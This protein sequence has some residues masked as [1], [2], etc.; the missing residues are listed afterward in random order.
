MMNYRGMFFLLL[1]L[2]TSPVV[3]QS[4]V[5]GEVTAINQGQRTLTLR[6]DNGQ[7]VTLMV[8]R[9]T[10]MDTRRGEVEGTDVLERLRIGSEVEANGKFTED[11][12]FMADSIKRERRGRGGN[13][14]P[15]LFPKNEEQLTTSRPPIGMKFARPS[16]PGRTRLVV[17][18]RDL[19]QLATITQNEI[20][21]QPT[22][23][24]SPG[25][26]S[27]T[28]TTNDRFGHPDSQEWK[29]MINPSAGQTP[30]SGTVTLIPGLNQTVSLRRPTVKAVFPYDI[31][32]NSAKMSVD[33]VD[34]SSQVRSTNR[35]VSWV[36]PY[37]LDYGAHNVSLTVVDTQGRAQ[38]E[39]W[40][41]N[42]ANS[43]SQP[44]PQPPLQA[45]TLFSPQPGAVV[46][47]QFQLTGKSEPN[48]QVQVNVRYNRELIKGVIGERRE[49]Q[50]NG[51]TD[52]AGY[53]ALQVDAGQVQGGAAMTM[54]VVVTHN[55]QTS[56]AAELRVTRQ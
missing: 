31:R 37:D 25:W 41:F 27:V 20:R 13:Q 39:N 32:S 21:W 28:V 9:M 46:A 42:I 29:F 1:L 17:D 33:G 30:A 36:A 45:P 7:T 2:L 16:Q 14:E 26:H 53:F 48:A 55:G 54:T 23:D 3:A 18:G 52:Q 15:E 10:K 24:L 11:G 47:P 8:D 12:R 38:T 51:T 6:Q 34:F 4:V 56:P 44:Q 19:T 40:S 43:K 22:Y 49:F 35:E 5:Q 50:V